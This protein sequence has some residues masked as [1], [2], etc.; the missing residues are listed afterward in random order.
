MAGAGTKLF[1][2]GQIL[3]AAQV[4][5]YLQDQVI[6]RFANA[7]TRDAA[8]G[9]VGEPTLAEGMFCYLDDTN[10][11]QSYTGSAWV[12]VVSSTYPPALVH[13]ATRTFSGAIT[14]QF[15]SVFSNEFLNYRCNLD[16]VA[17]GGTNFYV[18]LLVGT[19]AQ[20]GN[21]LSTN[22][23]NQLSAGSITKNTR[24]DQ[25]GLVGAAFSTYTSNYSFDWYSPFATDYTSY[26][27][28]GVGG[29]SATDSDFNQ[30]FARNIATTSIDGFEITTAGA[31]TLTG[32][33]RVYGYRNS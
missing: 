18:R 3:T 32:T 25:Y 29:R 23:Y 31:A 14:Q 2:D 24:S 22:A 21:I 1:V 27:C 12:N 10:T 19:T 20:S 13:V 26:Y 6:M 5:T 30:T 33:L 28:N 16:V 17:N 7:A 8:F 9:G 15:T 11:L 4:N